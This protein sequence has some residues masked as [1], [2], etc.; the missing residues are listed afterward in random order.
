MVMRNSIVS[1]AA[2]V[3]AALFALIAF[4]P[5]WAVDFRNPRAQRDL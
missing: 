3:A 1:A 5:A 4:Q 2:V